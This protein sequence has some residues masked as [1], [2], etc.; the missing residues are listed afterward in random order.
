MAGSDRS[1]KPNLIDFNA[2][3][4]GPC[5]ALKREVFDDA[6]HGEIMRTAVI[7]VSIVDRSHKDGQNPPETMNLQAR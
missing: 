7:P 5:Q 1:G 2:Q 6:A 4:C 3:W